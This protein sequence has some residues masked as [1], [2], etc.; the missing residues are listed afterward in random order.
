[1]NC[2]AHQPLRWVI[3]CIET[4]V[5]L[6]LNSFYILSSFSRMN[7]QCILLSYFLWSKLLLN[8]ASTLVLVTHSALSR[9]FVVPSTSEDRE[10]KGRCYMHLIWYFPSLVW[11]GARHGRS[12]LMKEVFVSCSFWCTNIYPIISMIL[13]HDGYHSTLRSLELTSAGYTWTLI[14]G[15]S[16]WS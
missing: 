13:I 10:R 9:Y 15:L 16:D 1:M 8:M 4:A 12:L 6:P 3:L 14:R 7:L 5:F 2:Y 11:R